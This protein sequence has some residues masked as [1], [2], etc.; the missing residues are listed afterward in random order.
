VELGEESSP[1]SSQ[2]SMFAMASPAPVR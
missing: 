1:Q 2:D